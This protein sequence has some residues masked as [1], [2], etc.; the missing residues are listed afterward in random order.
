VR[1]TQSEGTRTSRCA[2]A[3]RCAVA[4]RSS[5][6]SCASVTCSVRREAAEGSSSACTP[7]EMFASPSEMYEGVESSHT[8]P[9]PTQDDA[10]SPGTSPSRV[11]PQPESEPLFQ[12]WE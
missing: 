4:R 2:P 12:A 5:T 10:L 11:P 6:V 9:Q 3:G 8:H 7:S 1:E